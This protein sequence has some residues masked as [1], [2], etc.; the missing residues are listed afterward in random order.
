MQNTLESSGYLYDPFKT[1]NIFGQPPG[2][3]II[4]DTPKEPAMMFGAGHAIPDHD[5]PADD[6]PD[7][8]TGSSNRERPKAPTQREKQG[9]VN[10][11]YLAAF[12]AVLAVAL[13]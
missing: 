1:D 8:K 10:L 3:N 2:F 7:I 4:G 5:H 13:W 6:R 12:G 11:L 9:E